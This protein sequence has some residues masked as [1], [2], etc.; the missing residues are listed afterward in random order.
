MT[1]FGADS[2]GPIRVGVLGASGYTGADLIGFW[3]P[4]PRPRLR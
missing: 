3:S 4:T 2:A 1:G